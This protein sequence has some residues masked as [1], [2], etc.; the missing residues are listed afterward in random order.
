MKKDNDT[1]TLLRESGLRVT[2]SRLAVLEILLVESAPLS[3]ED[4][5][6]KLGGSTNITTLYRMLDIFTDNDI[7]HR[8]SFRDGRAYFEFQHDHHHHITCTSCGVREDVDACVPQST[9]KN[10]AKSQKFDVVTSH[11]L[12]F[13]GVCKKCKN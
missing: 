11:M 4:L 12:E 7:V 2:K 13:F 10:V 5:S 9:L 3:I 1:T 8:T 6:K